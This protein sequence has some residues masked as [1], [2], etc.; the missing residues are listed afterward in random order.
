MLE[1]QK[2]YIGE[3]IVLE[4]SGRI[5]AIN[6]AMLQDEIDRAITNGHERDLLLKM[7]DV[8]YISAAGLRVLRTLKNKSNVVRIVEPSIRVIDVMQITG[9][10]AVYELFMNMTDAL[11]ETGAVVNAHT[12]LELG[13]LKAGLPDITG[14]D[15]VP[16]LK[17]SI[18]EPFQSLKNGWEQEFTIAI[19]AGIEELVASGVTTVGDISETG[20]SIEPLLKARLRGIV[21]IEIWGVDPKTIDER[22]QKMVDIVEKWL[23]RMRN[24]LTL[25]I[26]AH[27]PYSLSPELWEKVLDYAREKQLP[28]CIHVAES[29]AEIQYLKDGTGALN[30]YYSERNFTA[31]G[32]SPVAYLAELG[33][34]DLKPLLI[35][36]VQV[37][38]EDIALIK[39]YGCTVVHCPRSNLRLKCGRMPLEKFLEA[40]IPILIG[41]DSLVSSPSLNIFDEL[42]VATALH[43]GKVDPQELLRIV[44]GTLPD[45]L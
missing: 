35:H 18:F 28:L 20:L 8:N 45:V 17:E 30:D 13:W 41:T 44:H 23:P 31:P 42:E 34:L 6:C 43:Y 4:I 14:K 39:K 1:I 16:W 10:D 5:D 25:G 2:S 24:G 38:D 9:L 26:A 27:T 15:F 11:Y 7:T 12:H 3:I 37:N 40:D 29:P 33:A 36:A 22:F 32:K 19:E 21:Y